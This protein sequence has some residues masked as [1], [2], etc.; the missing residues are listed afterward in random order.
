MIVYQLH[1]VGRLNPNIGYDGHATIVS[2]KVF[3]DKAEASK[4]IPEFKE[5][6]VT[7]KTPCDPQYMDPETINVAI[8]ELELIG[9]TMCELCWEG[10]R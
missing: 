4:H 1:A 8:I 6:C 3:T 2:R 9:D 5:S 10:M 7:P